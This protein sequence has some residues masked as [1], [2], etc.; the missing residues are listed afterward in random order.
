[1]YARTKKVGSVGR[2]GPRIGGKIRREVRKIEDKA[3]QNRCTSCGKKVRRIASGIW[4]CRFCGMNFTGGAYYTVTK[5]RATSISKPELEKVEVTP[6]EE[7]VKKAAKEKPK[8]E[9]K[10]PV[11]DSKTAPAE[12][13]EATPS[14]EVSDAPDEEAA[15][16]EESAAPEEE[17]ETVPAEDEASP[18][19]EAV[20]EQ[21]VEDLQPEESES[22]TKDKSES[23]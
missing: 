4:E 17:E 20:P 10:A 18:E 3:K 23:K 8:K 22:K 13:E 6:K 7:K 14:D 12:E 16:V 5:K 19:E 2:Y 11:E 15:P 9:E 21:E 1:M